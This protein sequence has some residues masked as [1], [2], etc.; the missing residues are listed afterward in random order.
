MQTVDATQL[1]NHVGAV[2]EQAMLG[3]V[4]IERHGR[5]I[6]YLVPAPRGKSGDRERTAPPARKWN[7]RDEERVI[8]LCIKGDFRPSRWLRAGAPRTLAGVAA[9]LASE[10]GFDRTRMLA[11]AERLSPEMSTPRGFSRWLAGAPVQAGRFLPML[12][13]RMRGARQPFAAALNLP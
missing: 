4:A 2:L 12:R 11:L 13:A 5:I 1:K 9:I 10:D 8:D 7:R 6:A 3:P